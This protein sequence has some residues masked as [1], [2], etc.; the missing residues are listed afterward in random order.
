MNQVLNSIHQ[1]RSAVEAETWKS[2]IEEG[3]LYYL[4]WGGLGNQ[5]FGLSSAYSLFQKTGKPVI[6]DIANCEH[7]NSHGIPDSLFLKGFQDWAV[8]INSGQEFLGEVKS[9]AKS[10]LGLIEPEDLK[11]SFFGWVPELEMIRN[12]GLFQ[13]DTNI[14]NYSAKNKNEIGI[15]VRIGDYKK[16]PYLGILSVHYYRKSLKIA[17][18]KHPNAKVVFFSDD[19][20]AAVELAQ[21][22]GVEFFNGNRRTTID[23]LE[24]MSSV[25]FLICANSTFSFWA[26][27]LG[28]IPA[29]FPYPWYLTDPSWGMKLIQEKD[30]VINQWEFPKI[31]LSIKALIRRTKAFTQHFS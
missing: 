23:T 30:V 9:S 25:R 8:F 24:A 16:Y 13:P 22:L 26:A 6:V 29:I 14:F 18:Q 15:H 3:G 2:R 1:I 10:L 28:D 31:V 19:E 21:K 4:L 11:G 12:S 7:M 27:F 17:L 20:S 5:L